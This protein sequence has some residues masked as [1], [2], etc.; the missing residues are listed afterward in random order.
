MR[1]NMRKCGWVDSLTHLPTFQVPLQWT[2][3]VKGVVEVGRFLSDKVEELVAE[4]NVR[5][6]PDPKGLAAIIPIHVVDCVF[7]WCKNFLETVK[8]VR[9]VYL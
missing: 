2:G 7:R 1:D 8:Q 6:V 4:I 5:L 3:K 9:T